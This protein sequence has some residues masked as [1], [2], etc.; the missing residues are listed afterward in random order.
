MTAF[1]SLIAEFAEKT[2]H[3]FAPSAD[4]SVSLEADGVLITVQSRE[5]RG[6]VVLFAFPVG[7]MKPEPATMQKALE[8]GAHGAGTDGFYLGISAEAFVLSGVMP[9]DGVSAENLAMKLLS[10]AAASKNVSSA[11]EHALAEYGETNAGHAEASV[12]MGDLSMLQV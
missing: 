1:E 9:L 2:G 6:D 11:L 7:D 12:A 5:D 8:L 3:Q 10:L 4:G